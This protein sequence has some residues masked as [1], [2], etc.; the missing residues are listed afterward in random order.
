MTLLNESVEV[1]YNASKVD[2]IGEYSGKNI[3]E[4]QDIIRG[5]SGKYHKWKTEY[6]SQCR[7]E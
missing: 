1:M 5:Y 7:K 6:N 3:S 2:T 4:K